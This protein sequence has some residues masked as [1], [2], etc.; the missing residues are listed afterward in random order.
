MRLLGSKA[1]RSLTSCSY[2]IIVATATSLCLSCPCT[3]QHCVVMPFQ[4]AGLARTHMNSQRR[5][6][7]RLGKRTFGDSLLSLHSGQNNYNMNEDVAKDLDPAAPSEIGSTVHEVI[8][9]NCNGEGK[10]VSKRRS[11]KSKYEYK[12]AKAAAKQRNIEF[13]PPPQPVLRYEPCS[14]CAGSGLVKRKVDKTSWN[15]DSFISNVHVAIIGG[16]IGG[17]ALAL[18][19]QH[20]N[21][22]FTVFERDASFDERKQGYGLTMQQGARALKGLGFDYAKEDSNQFGIQSKKHVVHKSDGTVVGEWGLRVWGRKKAQDANR[23]NAHISRQELRRLLMRKVNPE[24]IIWNHKLKSY[25]E[26]CDKV[27]LKFTTLNGDEVNKTTSLLVGADGIRSVV[28]RNKIGEEE[29]PLRYLGCVVILGICNI[30]V[31]PLTLIDGET[32]KIKTIRSYCFL[33]CFR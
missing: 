16:G 13:V 22:S 10:L 15:I 33:L 2:L 11:R 20:R 8:C 5:V 26:T 14:E 32:G 27:D 4:Q 21:I 6:I 19:L 23:Q 1:R 24:N 28:R 7:A 29:S 3:R 31:R 30:K 25:T 9:S 17:M 12:R 18:S